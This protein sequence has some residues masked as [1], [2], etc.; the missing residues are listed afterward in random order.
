MIKP[1]ASL[2]VEVIPQAIVKRPIR[3][4]IGGR[5][6][7]VMDSDDLDDFEGAS[8]KLGNLE[9]AVRHYR[10]FPEDRATIYIDEKIR[11]VEVITSL[12]REILGEFGLTDEALEWE[13][14][15]NPDL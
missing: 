15:K 13:R 6:D 9:I 3:E 1:I 12:V 8:F 14:A 7:L 2:S 11:K 4:I 5:A 10:G